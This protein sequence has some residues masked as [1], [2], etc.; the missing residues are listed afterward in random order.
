MTH[1]EIIRQA[2]GEIRDDT[3][4]ATRGVRPFLNAVA[5]WL[6]S[7]AAELEGNERSNPAS[8]E[9]AYCDEPG[10]MQSALAIARAYLN[11]VTP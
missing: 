5:D 4:V 6:D 8:E 3:L 2:A 7:C 9:F 10:A 1:A 11:E